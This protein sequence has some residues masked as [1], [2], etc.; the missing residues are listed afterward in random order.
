MKTLKLD[1]TE[2]GISKAAQILKNG[3]IVAIPTETVY[4][5]AA[6]AFCDNAV[7]KIFIAKGR[8]QDNPLIVH[9]E[10]ISDL[11]KIA[12]DIP[13]TAY[14]LADAFWPG[15]LTIVLKKGCA[16]CESV[17]AGLD[18]VAVRMPADKTARE[19]IRV[20]GLPLAAPSANISGAPSPTTYNHVINDMDG[21]IDAV[22]MGGSCNVG[23]ESSVVSLVGDTPKLLRPGAVT[24]EQL[25]Q[26]LPNLTVDP[27]V[28]SEPEKGEKVASPGMK[29]KHY[30]PNKTVY[31]IEGE[32]NKYVNFVNTK[33][34]ALAVCFKDEQ[35]K[36]TV[37]NICYGDKNAP[38]TLAH[39]LFEVLRLLDNEDAQCAYIHAPEKSGV[40]LAVYNRLIR[41]AAF[42]VINL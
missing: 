36:I 4:G 5:L 17:S 12:V 40:G 25:K 11:E 15:P 16:V 28:L 20:S 22:L 42:K 30:A 21:K 41:A 35:D 31:L 7:K 8:P 19:V 34:N 38:E 26:F 3:G 18:T 13:D 6:S 14:A 39:N 27:A 24:V 33:E 10:S 1:V 37:K 32:S 2:N 23:V 9:I 29:Y